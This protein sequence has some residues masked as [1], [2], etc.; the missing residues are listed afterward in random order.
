MSVD[1]YFSRESFI[2]P[3]SIAIAKLLNRMDMMGILAR[4][5]VSKSMPV[6]PMAA[7]P[8]TFM[9]SFSGCASFAP[10]AR[11]SPYPSCVDLP[12]PIYDSGVVDF[13]NGESSSR[14]LPASWVMTVL[15]T[16]AMLIRSQITRYGDSGLE[17][18]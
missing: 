16:S 13:Q 8:Q 1:L 17:S 14:G 3:N 7:S 6:M 9:Q 12:Q 2:G 5:Q 18:L 4:T 15:A 10:M 11:P